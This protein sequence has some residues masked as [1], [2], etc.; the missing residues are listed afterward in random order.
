MLRNRG[1]PFVVVLNK[2]DRCY[3]WK[4]CKDPP[5]RDALKVQPEG[6]I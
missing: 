2:V 1:T 4:I 3:N 5:I 6:A